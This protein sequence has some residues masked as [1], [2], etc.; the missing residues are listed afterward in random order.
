VAGRPSPSEGAAGASSPEAGQALERGM[1]ALHAF[2]YEQAIIDFD[3]AIAADPSLTMAHWGAAMSR[4]KLFWG[5]DDVA[6]GRAALRKLPPSSALPVRERLWVRAAT[7]LF[8]PGDPRSRRVAFAAELEQ[9]HA[10][11]PDDESAAW[12]AL[13]LLSTTSPGDPAGEAARK[14]AAELAMGVFQRNPKHPGAA[15]YLIHAYDTPEDAH[16]ALPAARAYAASAPEAFHARHMPAHIFARLGMWKEALASCHSAWDASVAW[17][18][19]MKLPPEQHDWHSLNWII[20]INFERGRRADA[21]KAMQDY[22]EAVKRG[23]DHKTRS[24]YAQQV[25]SY[26]ARTGEWQRVDELLA[27]LEAPASDDP[28]AAGASAHAG[29]HACGGHAA[30]PAGPPFALFERRA[31]LSARL[32]AAAMQ[33]KLPEATRL[34]A[35]QKAL[36]AELR[37]FMLAGLGP[38]GVAE[39]E[40]RNAQSDTAMMARARGDDRALLAALEPIAERAKHEF[41]AEG[42]AGGILAQEEI[43]DVLLRLGRNREALAAYEQVLAR[44]AGR[45][46]S[47]LGAARAAARTGQADAARGFREKL[48]AVWSEA[49]ASTPGLDEAKRAA[50]SGAKSQ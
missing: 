9:L 5:E 10:Q 38:E 44:H 43:G 3:A 41:A 45:A 13:A 19:R 30:A 21:D 15:H 2:W 7:R 37:P 26:V 14:R 35:E 29:G 47:L 1:R 20:E 48:L 6:G 22:A 31:A 36:E 8:G 27:P 40:K 12:L 50:G 23:L 42:T 46:H 11:Q 39:E 16:L 4:S 25:A 34:M 28:A 49:D 33:R 18:K 24:N 32:R 17:A